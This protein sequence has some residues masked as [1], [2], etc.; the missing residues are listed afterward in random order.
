MIMVTQ[1]D[2]I[3]AIAGQLRDQIARLSESADHLSINH[4]ASHV[5]DIRKIARDHGLG[6]L[7]DIAHGLESALARSDSR[8][9]IHSWLDMMGE[10]ASATGTSE[11]WLASIGRR[12]YG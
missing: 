2:A 6:P 1:N 4:L 10:A 9:L 5:D 3:S 11:V 7:A 8:V 12:L